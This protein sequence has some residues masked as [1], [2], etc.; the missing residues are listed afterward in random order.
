MFRAAHRSSSG[1]L[2]CTYR[3][4]FIYPCG[5]RPLSR[6]NENNKFYY[7]DAS[8]WYFYW[9]IYDVRIHEYQIYKKKFCAFGGIS[10]TTDETC[11]RT[12]IG[13]QAEARQCCQLWSCKVDS[14]KINVN[15]CAGL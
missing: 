12:K 13:Q 15:F 7:K 6:P 5:D 2:N 10:E 11:R 3:L 9:V 8:C 14:N 4:W 1:A